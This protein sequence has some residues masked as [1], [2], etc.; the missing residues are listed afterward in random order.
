MQTNTL[1]I[2][3]SIVPYTTLSTM[4][5]NKHTKKAFLAEGPTVDI[6]VACGMLT[7]ISTKTIPTRVMITVIDGAREPSNAVAAR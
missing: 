4:P 7:T 2:T 6:T 3:A 1:G 5:T